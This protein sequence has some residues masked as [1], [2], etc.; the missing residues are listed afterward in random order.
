MPAS[1]NQLLPL[2]IFHPSRT[3]FPKPPISLQLA[4]FTPPRRQA[5]VA[6]RLLSRTCLRLNPGWSTLQCMVAHPTWTST[7]RRVP[8]SCAAMGSPP[9]GTRST[10]RSVSSRPN[11]LPSMMP[12]PCEASV[13]KA[14]SERCAPTAGGKN[15]LREFLDLVTDSGD[16]NEILRARSCVECSLYGHKQCPV[17]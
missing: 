5:S 6:K 8:W 15:R 3:H 13:G 16:C 17:I 14:T 7:I 9:S 12:A 1:R 2:A 10:S 11:P 4:H